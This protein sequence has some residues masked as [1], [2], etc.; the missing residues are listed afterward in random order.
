MKRIFLTLFIV[1]GIY[2][3]FKSESSLK[4]AFGLSF[5]LYAMKIM[6]ESFAMLAG[7]RLEAFL[8]KATDKNYKSFLFGL[9]STSIMQSS[10]L[11][12]L[13]AISFVSAG[14]ITLGGGIGI[15]YGSNLGATVGIWLI[16]IFGFSFDIAKFAMPFI[17]FGIFMAFSKVKAIKGTGML[18]LSVG[19]IFFGIAYMKEGFESFGDMVDLSKY[20][21]P[22][23]KGAVI[24][25]FIGIVVTALLQSSHA[26]LTLTLSA[27]ATSQISY[28]NSLAI[29]LGSNIGSTITAVIG[30]L[31]ASASGKKLTMAHVIFNIIMGFTVLIFLW[32]VMALIDFL[33]GILHI[34]ADNYLLKLALFH[35]TTNL[36]G[37]AVFYPNIGLMERFLNEKIKFKTKKEHIATPNYLNDDIIASVEASKLAL[38]NESLHLFRNTLSVVTKSLH[39]SKHDITSGLNPIEVIKKRSNIKEIDFDK[40]Y[41]TRFK[42]LYNDIITFAMRVEKSHPDDNDPR[43][44]S[45]VRRIAIEC[46]EILKDMKSIEPNFYK[47]LQSENE[48]IRGEYN[49]LRLQM[50]ILLRMIFE[51]KDNKE[52]FGIARVLS[53]EIHKFDLLSSQK[54]NTLLSLNQ[55]SPA[56]ATSLMN[57][58]HLLQDLV[59]STYKIAK[60]SEIYSR[61]NSL[62]LS[63]FQNVK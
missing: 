34:G 13:L 26:T 44:F 60:I 40:L 58:S 61:A 56:M 27:L 21:M 24:F 30:S 41:A 43:A 12:S 16:A 18:I 63:I 55:I 5:F 38:A 57:D 9:T 32:Q 62:D 15:I 39:F 6:E 42:P 45:N 54:I 10:G 19:L 29:A 49:N 22:G 36:L 33:A 47:Y 46:A 11:V 51:V 3:I 48:Y 4:I 35:F 7:G 59:R 53:N 8:R 25:M 28:E 37:I 20:A 31:G 52:I 17:I 2:L 14:L 50:L 1:T 23:Y